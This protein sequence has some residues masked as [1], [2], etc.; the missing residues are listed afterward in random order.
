MNAKKT[1]IQRDDATVIPEVDETEEIMDVPEAETAEAEAEA[2]AEDNSGNTDTTNP[3][4]AAPAEEILDLSD[5]QASVGHVVLGGGATPEPSSPVGISQPLIP[6]VNDVAGFS[7]AVV[8]KEELNKLDETDPS[9]A[10]T[11]RSQANWLADSAKM[12]KGPTQETLDRQDHITQMDAMDVIN[13]AETKKLTDAKLA[14]DEIATR[15][16]TISRYESEFEA[17]KTRAT[18]VK[19]EI[20]RLKAL[21][22]PPEP[23]KKKGGK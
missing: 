15:D 4:E 22:D 16:E 17:L 3:P 23:K 6:V 12:F 19:S 13:R 14:A 2:P 8:P 21:A 20:E 9:R 5:G 10:A 11:L 18:F 7:E 1:T